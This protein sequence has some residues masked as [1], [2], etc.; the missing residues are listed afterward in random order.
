MKELEERTHQLE[1]QNEQLIANFKQRQL[2]DSE[3]IQRLNEELMAHHESKK[4]SMEEVDKYQRVIED[5]R[6][7]VLPS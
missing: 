4:A 1:V 5:A 6:Y 2:K 7:F 3:I